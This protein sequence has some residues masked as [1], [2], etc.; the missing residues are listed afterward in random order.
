MSLQENMKKGLLFKE[1]GHL[2]KDDREYEQYL[3]TKRKECKEIIYDYNLIRPSDYQAK[4]EL[5]KKL[6]GKCDSKIYIEAPA[7]FA[8]GCNSYI[9]KNFYANFNLTIVDDVE[10]FIGDNV[11]IGPNVTLTVT[12]HPLSSEYR[13]QGTHFSL[14]ITIGN[15]VWIGANVVILPGV[16]IGDNSVIGAGSVVTKDVAS[17]TLAYGVPCK[18]IRKI[19]Q[20]DQEYFRKG[21]KVN[22]DW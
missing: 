3:E 5:L 15:N 22:F 12:G 17:E 1:Y 4:H 6:L 18:E 2:N 11:M 7:Y 13:S 8:Y 14:P 20:Y 10:V 16:K 9:G 19:N 21:Q